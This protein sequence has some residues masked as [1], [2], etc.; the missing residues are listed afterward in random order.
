M[1]GDATIRA[2]DAD[3]DRAAA[4]L[5]EHLAAGRLT[6]E[7]FDERL[8]KV[9][10]A[11]TLGELAEVMTDLPATDLE[12]LPSNSLDRSAA[13]PRLPGRRSS[14]SI[15]AAQGRF[16]PAWRAAWGSWLAISLFLVV[17]WLASGAGGGLW[18]LWVALALGA[19][20]LGRWIT[21]APARSERRTAARRRDHRRR[22][23]ERA[24]R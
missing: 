3:R 13:E 12:Q 4:T 14:P 1:A 11:K 6:I 16:S 22:R 15:E 24:G 9:Y 2:S 18:F 23:D 7:E 8:D 10:A 5:R 21:G 17:I 19:L 20:L